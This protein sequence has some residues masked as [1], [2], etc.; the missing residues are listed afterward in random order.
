MVF[1]GARNNPSCDGERGNRRKIQVQGKDF[2]RSKSRNLAYS[3]LISRFGSRIHYVRT[4]SLEKDLDHV[5]PSLELNASSKS[6]VSVLPCLP[7]I[8]LCLTEERF[9]P[10]LQAEQAN[11]LE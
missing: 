2:Q 5:M 4:N 10:T 11:G 8:P 1:T 9:L 6:K 7:Q 3:N